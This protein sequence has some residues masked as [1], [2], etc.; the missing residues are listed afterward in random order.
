MHFEY[1]SASSGIDKVFE[2]SA[3]TS[4]GAFA[5]PGV[6]THYGNWLRTPHHTVHWAGTET[7]NEWAGYIEGALQ[8]GERAAQ[9]VLEGLA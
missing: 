2:P 3:E 5:P 7:A 9:E 1:S 8:A 6:M 4:Y